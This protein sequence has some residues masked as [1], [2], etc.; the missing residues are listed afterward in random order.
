M[1]NI[2][3]FYLFSITFFSFIPLS[4]ANMAQTYFNGTE[5]S[6]IYLVSDNEK[7]NNCIVKKENLF[8]QIKEHSGNNLFLNYIAAIQA[9]YSIYSDKKQ[10][11]SLIFIA[12]NNS[13]EYSIKI[14]NKEIEN[15]ILSPDMEYPFLS[16]EIKENKDVLYFVKF[17]EQEDYISNL[18][19]II[20]F[21]ADLQEGENDI[22]IAYESY[23]GLN[24]YG[25]LHQYDLKYAVYPSQYWNTFPPIEIE[26]Q[27]PEHW[28]VYKENIGN[29][30]QD[31]NTLKWI[32]N[33]L[34][35]GTLEWVFTKKTN[36]LQD[37]VLFLSPVGFMLITFFVGLLLHIIF[38]KKRNH[39]KLNLLDFLFVPILSYIVFFLAYPFIE[40]VID[41]EGGN[42]GYYFFFI[43]TIVLAIPFYGLVIT[44]C[45]YFFYGK[46]KIHFSFG[47]GVLALAL[48]FLLLLDSIETVIAC[49]LLMVGS[50]LFYLLSKKSRVKTFYLGSVFIIS[51]LMLLWVVYKTKE[52]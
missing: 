29:I 46:V 11:I 44:L 48:S 22:I 12:E 3:T 6:S 7:D 52:F 47:L 27:I 1:K 10:R 36:F 41:S 35:I 40:W 2:L 8:I 19:D 42:H 20:F 24:T 16:K 45:L 13:G 26:M 43:L 4:F 5:S 32:A 15:T 51:L 49:S 18:N 9:K 30:I 14:N 50:T 21:Q 23:L 37:A 38:I 39:S 33:D 17:K 25:F 34:S 31:G 28:Q